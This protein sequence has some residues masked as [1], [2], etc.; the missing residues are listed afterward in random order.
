VSVVGLDPV[1]DQVKGQ[2]LHRRSSCTS[3]AGRWSPAWPCRR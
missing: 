3:A 1:I 2:R